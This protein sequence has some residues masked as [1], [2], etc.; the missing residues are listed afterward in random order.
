[1]NTDTTKVDILVGYDGSPSAAGAI[2]IGA[3]LLPEAAANVVHVWTPPF[4][5]RELR[6][7]LLRR[8]GSLDDLIARVEREGSAEADRLAADG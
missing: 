8:A 2:E 5:S 6:A 1:M 7:R 4:G 3:R